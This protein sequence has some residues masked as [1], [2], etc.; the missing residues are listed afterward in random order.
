MNVI[1][2]ELPGVLLLEPKA[3]RDAR[4]SFR[5]TFR[6]DEFASLGIENCW[7]QDN[8]SVSHHGVLR[9]LHFQHPTGQAKL[10][11]VLHGSVFDVAVDVRVGSPTFRRAVWVTLSDE[12]HRQVFIPTGFAHGFVVT[13]ESAVV[14]YKCSS[15]WAPSHELT[16]RW[17]DASLGIPWPV[18][19]PIVSERDAAAP[20]LADIALDRLPRATP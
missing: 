19:N 11:Q 9:G 17:N 3:F 1:A 15:Y 13:S 2:T 4:G 8:V 16:V 6:A 12:N 18:E 20:L 14:S 7:V 5:T 10:L